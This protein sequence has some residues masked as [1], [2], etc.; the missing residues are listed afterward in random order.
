MAIHSKLF[1]YFLLGDKAVHISAWHSCNGKCLVTLR[2]T[3]TWV[4]VF[5]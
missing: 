1:M 4:Q 2:T 3:M 5:L